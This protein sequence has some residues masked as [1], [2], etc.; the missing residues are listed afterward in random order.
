[1]IAAI[2]V[3]LL[4]FQA[5]LPAVYL[6]KMMAV[7]GL[8]YAKFI[9]AYDQMEE[10]KR[11]WAD[12]MGF[13][14]LREPLSKKKLEKIRELEARTKA[15]GLPVQPVENVDEELFAL[16]EL[17]EEDLPSR[18][19]SLK[20]QWLLT[21]EEKKM[22]DSTIRSISLQSKEGPWAEKLQ[23][24][25][26]RTGAEYKEFSFLWQGTFYADTEYLRWLSDKRLADPKMQEQATKK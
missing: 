15:L 21:L 22:L 23:S 13:N 25:C 26:E 17:T 6:A 1:M 16:F 5:N 3:A 8:G 9:S 20:G 11:R 2:R 12:E 19:H 10:E 24:L 7:V 18:L 14:P 4:P